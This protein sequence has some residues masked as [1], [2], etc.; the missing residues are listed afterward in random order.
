MSHPET[1]KDFA[2]LAMKKGG[3]HNNDD[4]QQSSTTIG[5]TSVLSVMILSFLIRFL[6]FYYEFDTTLSNEIHFNTPTT[7]FKKLK[8]G[9]YFIS[10]GLSPYSSVNYIQPPLLLLIF[11]PLENLSI[12]FTKLFFILFDLFI[13]YFL[14]LLCKLT[15]KLKL[16]KQLNNNNLPFILMIVYLFNPIMI[17]SCI[18]MSTVIFNNFLII[19]ILFFTMKENIVMATLFLALGTYLTIY[20]IT[21]FIGMILLLKQINSKNINL[22]IIKSIIFF[23]FWLILIIYA[24][25]VLLDQITN[26]KIINNNNLIS[27]W[28]GEKRFSLFIEFIQQCYLY[29]LSLNDLTPNWGNFWYFFIEVFDDFR[30]FFLIIFHLHVL[31]YIIPMTIRFKNDGLFWCLIQIAIISV[32]KAYPCLGDFYFYM[33][34]L[35]IYKDLAQYMR[36]GFVIV[37]LLMC[38]M[39]VGPI[40]FNTWIYKGTGNANFFYFMTLMFL[41]ANVL[42]IVEFVFAKLKFANL[43]K[44]K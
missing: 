39:F 11:M 10:I 13:G 38:S 41:V 9:L 27:N 21:L 37:S 3:D 36:Y 24:S 6:L 2:S 31:A 15:L 29:P 28:L 33:T 19:G 5:T 18:S 40:C 30:L 34:L 20:P 16:I 25:I 7:S 4:K 23:I 12:W 44:L 8:E 26:D 14:Y 17:C 42:V 1:N 32:F 35:V 43:A 22:K